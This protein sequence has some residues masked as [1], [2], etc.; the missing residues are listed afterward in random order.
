MALRRF[1]KNVICM[2]G[3]VASISLG[4]IIPF[5]SVWNTYTNF[6]RVGSLCVCMCVCECVCV[7]VSVYMCM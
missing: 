1:L 7:Y 2:E 6:V 4:G 5:K 3:R